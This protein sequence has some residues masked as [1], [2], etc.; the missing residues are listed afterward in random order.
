LSGVRL[1][2]FRVH[3]FFYLRSKRADF[4][5]AYAAMWHSAQAAR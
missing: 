4:T 5:I 2:D 3:H 1:S